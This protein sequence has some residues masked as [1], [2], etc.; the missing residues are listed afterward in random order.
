M[1][2]LGVIAVVTLGLS[3]LAPLVLGTPPA[4]ATCQ[5]AGCAAPVPCNTGLG[6]CWKPALSARWQYQLQAARDKAGNCLYPSTGGINVDI[7]G[8]PFT[9][10]GT[11]SPTVFD[12][13]FQ[14]DGACT[15]GTIT[16][17]NGAAVAAIHAKGAK[18]ICYIDAGGAESFR[19]DFPQYDAFNT[20][21]GGCLFGKPISGFRN[22]FWLNINNDRGQRDFIL[23][24]I[25][26]RLDHCVAD[27]FDGVEMDVVDAWSNRTGL[28]ITA[29]TQLLF[30]SALA[31]LAHSKGLTV[32]LKNDV[33]QVPDLAPYFDYAI[34][35]QCQ[36]YSECGT[37][38]T[39][40]VNAGKA[41]FQVEYKLKTSKF[42]PP[43]NADD[44]NAIRKTFDLF[45]TPWTP[46]R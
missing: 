20:S 45:D 5:T 16:Q 21:C 14:T 17:E 25:G 38:T 39:N 46:C 19:P 3:T 41:V 33:E 36:Q 15:G 37:Y 23:G 30:N 44:R 43:A 28:T 42:C 12:I 26:A 31:N 35:E 24:R 11:V 7:G 34:N 13:D 8:T 1:R 2:R 32:A 4:E 29:D 27:G 18:A 9:G 22:E 10:G 6:A 40:F